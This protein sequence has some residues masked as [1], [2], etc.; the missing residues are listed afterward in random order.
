MV[1]PQPST[2]LQLSSEVLLSEPLSNFVDQFSFLHQLVYQT[3]VKLVVVFQVNAPPQLKP[4]E[5][6]KTTIQNTIQTAITDFFLM[7]AIHPTQG[8]KQATRCMD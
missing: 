1:S 2:N 5:Q 7:E 6:F 8:Q 4:L 3:R